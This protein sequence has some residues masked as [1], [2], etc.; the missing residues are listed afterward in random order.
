MVKATR[1]RRAL[2]RSP[3]CDLDHNR[4]GDP[5]ANNGTRCRDRPGT[6]CAA[7]APFRRVPAHFVFGHNALAALARAPCAI[8][9][10]CGARPAG[11]LAALAARRRR[12]NRATGGT[13]LTALARPA[14]ALA[15]LGALARA[16][17]L[18]VG[19]RSGAP[20]CL[21]AP[22]LRPPARATPAA[23]PGD[24]LP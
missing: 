12:V 6:G 20:A 18:A 16:P 15:A 19:L 11:A 4:A 3:A 9:P 14:G 24:G 13:S 10:G 17:A 5:P 1:L 21:G 8:C 22:A 23:L 7:G 2:R